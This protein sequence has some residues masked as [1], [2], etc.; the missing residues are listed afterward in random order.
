M[1]ETVTDGD[2]ID[3][4]AP[5]ADESAAEDLDAPTVVDDLAPDPAALADVEA[6]TILDEPVAT[7]DEDLERVSDP[8]RQY[9]REIHRVALLTA[10]SER[11]LAA[12]MEEQVALAALATEHASDGHL[13]SDADV[14]LR[15]YERLSGRID[16]I[17]ALFAEVGVTDERPL[18]VRLHNRKVRIQIDALLDLDL[19]ARLAT[20]L[21]RSAA[22]IETDLVQL[23]LESRLLLPSLLEFPR[24][25]AAQST[26]SAATAARVIREREKDVH[27]SFE[28][29][30]HVAE[31]AEQHLIEANLRLVV[32]IA[33]R[34]ANRGMELLDLIQ[35]GN[36]GLMRAVGKFDYR[37]G[38]KFS[39][40]A[41]W[42]IRQSI[43]RA[44][45]YQSRTIRVPVHMV[46][47]INRLGH[48]TRELT[49]QLDR[50]PLAVEIAL[51]LGLF[52]P[53]LEEELVAIAA[54]RDSTI[55]VPVDAGEDMRRGAILRSG[56]LQ[57]PR[58]IP[59]LMWDEINQAAGRVDQA[60]LV[61]RQPVSLETPVGTEQDNHL[62]DLIEDI[63]SPEPSEVAT[64]A[65]LR[66]QVDSILESMNV[67]ER[68]VIEL[69]FGLE[70]GR[71]RTLEEVGKEFGV[72]RE[73]VRQIEAKAL[74][75]LR[76]PQRSRRL[77][78]YLE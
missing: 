57:T 32:S 31:A 67:R 58:L 30:R 14:A 50:D 1:D 5:E 16:L 70:D 56:I 24:F 9:L 46:E 13:A 69:R 18:F 43:S 68:R 48:V 55:V 22:E 47:I 15:L 63:T 42:W 12:R 40:Y 36:Q 35:E 34:Y 7:P 61:S 20:R 2:L 53:G 54:R 75:K 10:E 49:Q 78:D 27:R 39:T 28:R 60:I 33:K 6:E 4:T 64:A 62:G 29:F 11:H 26:P 8:V 17:Q 65:L 59:P 76:H 72:T 19:V 3:S 51:M 23:S 44:L 37:R 41:T 74:R 45:A 66:S 71:S 77:R 25:A 38:F 73:R 52:E 21:G